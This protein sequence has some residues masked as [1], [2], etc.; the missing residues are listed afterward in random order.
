[1]LPR[2]RIVFGLVL[3]GFLQMLCE[4]T[5]LGKVNRHDVMKNRDRLTGEV[6]RLEQGAL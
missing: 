1:M 2:R 4:A 3:L 6:K 5:C